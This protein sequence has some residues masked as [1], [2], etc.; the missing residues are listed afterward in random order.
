VTPLAPRLNAEVAEALTIAQQLSEFCAGVLTMTHP[1]AYDQRLL[2]QFC[3]PRFKRIPVLT[4]D[5]NRDTLQLL[6][7]YLAHSQYHFIGVADPQ[8]AI[9]TAE[10]YHPQVILLDVML[11]EVDGW[12]LLGR[13]RQHPVT[14]A[15]PIIVCTIL[16]QQQLALALGAAAFLRKP[17]NQQ[18]LLATLDHQ[19]GYHAQEFP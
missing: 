17:I 10:K 4:I 13:L 12:E 11:P 14:S 7:R 2:I 5:D 19:V 1:T 9:A 18:T 15:A 3:L 8:Q 16:P 6:Q